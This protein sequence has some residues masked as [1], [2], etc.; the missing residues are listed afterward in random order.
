MKP[1][2]IIIDMQNDFF[3]KESLGEQLPH[4]SDAINGLTR[5]ARCHRCPVVW[6]VTQFA[7][8]LSDAF[9]EMKKKRIAVCIE[10]TDGAELL[11]DLDV[12]P[13]DHT[14]VKKRY[15]SFFRTELD[16]LLG[17]IGA[18]HLVL[19]G[20][21]THACIRAT[22]IDAYQRDFEVILAEECIASYDQEHHDVSWRYMNGK[23][24]IGMSNEAINAFLSNGT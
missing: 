1:V 11:S 3:Q 7:A 14:I 20:I 2:S 23:I 6:V 18:T 10:G 21:N 17:D 24:A 12:Q 4:L 9:L 16:N 22:A 5:V 8:D 13:D 15:S 19:A